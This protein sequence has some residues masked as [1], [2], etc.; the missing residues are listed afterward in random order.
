MRLFPAVACLCCVT[1]EASILPT[2]H[3]E[4]RTVQAFQDYVAKFEKEVVVR[5]TE[6]GKLWIDG[7]GCCVR[8]GEMEGGKPIVQPRMNADIAGGSIHHFSG[9]MHVAGGAIDD[10]R[11]VMQDYPNYPKYF[12]PDVGKGAGERQPDSTPADEHYISDLSLIQ[13]TVWMSVS[14]ESVYDTHYRRLDENHW[15]SISRSRS[16]REWLDPK[17]PGKGFWN[18]GEDHG[19][20]WRT[21]TYWL[22]RQSGDGVD[23]EVDSISLSRPVPAG[24]GWWGT[25]RTRDAVDKM[26]HDMRVAVQAVHSIR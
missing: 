22:V 13:N 25:K 6:S 21:N 5:Y 11:R 3:L 4:T 24:F 10:V 15:V 8:A 20:L 14:Y 23:L 26:L 1:L 17:D 18:E 7:T 9:V 19:L 2:V 16:I 12:K